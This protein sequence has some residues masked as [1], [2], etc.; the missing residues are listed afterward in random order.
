MV[1]RQ[2]EKRAKV[3]GTH[4]IAVGKFQ[5]RASR[6]EGPADLDAD[7]CLLVGDIFAFD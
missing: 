7:A 4:V 6:V 2:E 5:P 3:A 1:R